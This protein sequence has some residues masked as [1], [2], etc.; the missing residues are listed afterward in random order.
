[1]K[2]KENGATLGLT[3]NGNTPSKQSVF[4][5]AYTIVENLY[6]KDDLKNG[7]FSP[8]GTLKG[9]KKLLDSKILKSIYPYII[10]LSGK[11]LFKVLALNGLSILILKCISNTELY[12]QVKKN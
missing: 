9:N 6:D 10:L 5:F 12:F 8:S 7:Y 1:M 4:E 11:N 3:I 2:S